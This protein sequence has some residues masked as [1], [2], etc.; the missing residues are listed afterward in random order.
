MRTRGYTLIELLIVI[1][2]VTIAGFV[3]TSVSTGLF[4]D[5]RGAVTNG[6]IRYE[7]L[8]SRT[9]DLDAVIF[10]TRIAKLVHEA[11]KIFV[12]GGANSNP[13]NGA[14]LAP[15]QSGIGVPSLDAFS[16]ANSALANN[17]YGFRQAMPSFFST[18]GATSYDNADFSVLFM[19]GKSVNLGVATVKRSVVGDKVFYSAHLQDATGFEA[20]YRFWLSV[21]EDVWDEPVGA[22]HSWVLYDTNLRD[23][24][25]GPC[26][27]IFPDPVRLAGRQSGI[28][29]SAYSY[30]LAPLK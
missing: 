17:S 10:H 26:K 2:L 16:S 12:F 29:A 30:S 9:A 15:L 27:V 18:H 4:A 28:P 8:P 7:A 24:E 14:R 21:A 5:K 3:F 1:V 19:Q 23:Y 25:E 6:G 13:I 11:G 20:A 22:T